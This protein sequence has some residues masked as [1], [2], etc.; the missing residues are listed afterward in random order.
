MIIRLNRIH[1]R[2]W[3]T[4][5][6]RMTTWLSFIQHAQQTRFLQAVAEYTRVKANVYIRQNN[7]VVNGMADKRDRRTSGT[8]DIRRWHHV[9]AIHSSNGSRACLRRIMVI[10]ALASVS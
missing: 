2:D 5:S 1:E 9:I 6:H 7:T 10:L 4:D 8:K 3:R